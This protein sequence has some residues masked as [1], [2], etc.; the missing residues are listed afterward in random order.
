MKYY[1]HLRGNNHIC[2]H[3]RSLKCYLVCFKTSSLV[4]GLLAE[5]MHCVTRDLHVRAVGFLAVG[6]SGSLGPQ[7]G[8]LPHLMRGTGE[9]ARLLHAQQ[10][11][12]AQHGPLSPGLPV[13]LLLVAQGQA[14]PQVQ[15]GAAEC[16]YRLRSLFVSCS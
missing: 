2:L 4:S 8:S 16:L 7:C 9:E 1:L 13:Q 5:A 14:K 12:D 6:L 15:V 10:F 3:I 11:L